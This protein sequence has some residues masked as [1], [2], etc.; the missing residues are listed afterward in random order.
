M[1]INEYGK[2]KGTS[3]NSIPIDPNLLYGMV[4]SMAGYN[5]PVQENKEN[6]KLKEIS[7]LDVSVH[8]FPPQKFVQGQKVI[9]HDDPKY[10]LM[11]NQELATLENDNNIFIASA[12][13]VELSRRHEKSIKS[14]LNNPNSIQ[15]K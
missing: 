5:N 3:R 6:L 1:N 7:I 10:S 11:T 9:Y 4:L 14:I 12:A 2:P 13:M 8:T 15:F